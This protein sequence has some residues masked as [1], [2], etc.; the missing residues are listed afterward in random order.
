MRGPESMHSQMGNLSQCMPECGEGFCKILLALWATWFI[1]YFTICLVFIT[2]ID[3]TFVKFDVHMYIYVYISI[4]IFFLSF[5]CIP[6]FTPLSLIPIM[7]NYFI[8]PHVPLA[9][10]GLSE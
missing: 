6:T 4:Y 5:I 3:Q 1:F 7:L 2:E 9:Y 10:C 8:V